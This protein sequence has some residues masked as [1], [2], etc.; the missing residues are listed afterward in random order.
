MLTDICFSCF[1]VVIVSVVASVAL[2]GVLARYLRRRKSP[3]PIRRN[4]KIGGGRRSRNSIRSPN[5]M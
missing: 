2:L 1:Q 4:R 5:G 3:R